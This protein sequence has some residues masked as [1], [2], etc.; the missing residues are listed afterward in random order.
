M[1]CACRLSSGHTSVYRLIK[2]DNYF[3]IT[4]A[5]E[6]IIPQGRKYQLQKR[7]FVLN[8]YFKKITPTKQHLII[9]IKIIC[10]PNI[11]DSRK[12][13]SNS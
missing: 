6:Q 8:R 11:D 5:V 10:P 13:F 1:P 4:H 7:E 2:T 3:P 12:Q 9:L